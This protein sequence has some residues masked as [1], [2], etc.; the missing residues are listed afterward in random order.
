MHISENGLLLGRELAFFHHTSGAECGYQTPQNDTFAILHPKNEKTGTLYP[1]YVVF[2]SAGHDVY[3][4]VACTWQE[5]NHDIYHVPE[6]MYGLFLDCRA[7]GNT[8]WWWGGI[9]A[10]GEGDPSRRGTALQ[11]V[12]KRCVDTIRH[13]LANYPI[14][15]NRVYGAGNSMGGSGVLG[16]GLNHGDIFAAVLANVPAGVEHAVDRCALL[17]GKPDGFSIPDPPVVVDYSAQDDMWSR[18]HEKLYR[19]MRENRYAMIGYFGN[20]GHANNLSQMR[21]VNDLILWQ[22]MLSVRLNEA[23]PAFTNAASDDKNPWEYPGIEDAGQVNAY[24]K[25]ENREDTPDTF[26][27]VV[28]LMRPED[29]QTKRELPTETTADV[30]LR[31]IQRFG[32]QP[33]DRIAYTCGT[34]SGSVTIPDSGVLTIPA[35]VISQTGCL[36]R[37][38]HTAP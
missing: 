5:G 22:D 18:G 13:V 8:D 34:Q 3:S 29:W 4:A 9:N 11:P 33:G 12:E 26:A 28:S 23:N 31:R 21:K 38:T 24:F 10:Q 37:L 7:N 15:R 32:Y 2:H 14:D 25:W 6:D 20:F 27:M 35:L 19:G 1:L 17:G 36:L 30:T 16:I